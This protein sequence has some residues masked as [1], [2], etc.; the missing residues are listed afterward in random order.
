MINNSF[1]TAEEETA[2][3]WI[4]N[5]EKEL[6]KAVENEKLN[7]NVAKNVIFFLGIY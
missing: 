5:S 6:K 2:E 3:F 1:V 4:K 7:T